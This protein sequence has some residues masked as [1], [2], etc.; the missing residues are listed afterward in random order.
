MPP[1]AGG[2]RKGSGVNA[3]RSRRGNIALMVV[4]GGAVVA[5]AAFL[6]TQFLGRAEIAS[7][8]P[9]P[10]A[11]VA[12]TDPTITLRLQNAE[13]LHGLRVRI[14]GK[15]VQGRVRGA[16]DRLTV[17]SGTLREGRHVA[18]VSFRTRNLFARTVKRTWTF[19]IDVTRPA[20]AVARPARGAFVN[21]RTVPV[22]GKAEAG[23]QI[24]VSWKGGAAE[25]TAAADGSW[26]VRGKF[27]EGASVARVTATDRAGNSTAVL[28][29]MTVDTVGP[30]LTVAKLGDTPL[31][32][33]DS[34]LITGSVGND[35]PARL[36]FGARI[37]GRELPALPGAEVTGLPEVI[38]AVADDAPTGSLQVDGRRFTMGVGQLPQGRNRVVV[39]ARDRAGNVTEKKMTVLVD[40]TEEF[41]AYAMVRGAKGA[42]VTALQLR[43][44]SS[45]KY[46]GKTTGRFDQKTYK[47][48]RRYQKGRGFTPT[49][50]V[51]P[52]TLQAM[53]GRIVID[54]SE[55]KLRLIR[56]GK[57]VKTY[58]VATGSS[59]YPTPTGT[60]K[61]VNKQTNPTWIP[62]SSP[63][64]K[65]LGPIPPG[66]G[67]PLGTRWI[68]TSADAVGIHGTYAGYSVGTPASHGCLRMH[69]PE[70]E[71]LYEEV[72]IGMP[73][74]IKA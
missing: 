60:F 51:G 16:G 49:G 4:G 73:V 71:A 43:L 61:V 30:T 22:A 26:I 20:V 6:V 1:I 32:E 27:P 35:F 52:R 15:A 68:G 33:T 47:A 21:K 38:P 39:W 55:F 70:V 67:N 48:L 12:S 59:A 11:A 31:T 69:I 34:P 46:K 7:A 58:K 66:P 29:T 5:L 41:G 50:T 17:S 28:R 2:S 23:A 13:R 57:V 10:G 44:K 54:L 36:T 63:W 53:V 40:S 62:P 3:L 19:D 37:N 64:A 72:S 9:G 14:D 65:G 74:I 18:E 42:D 45:G 56:D 25:T 8:D 24:A